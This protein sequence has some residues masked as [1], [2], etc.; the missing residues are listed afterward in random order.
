MAWGEC[1][2]A[3]YGDEEVLVHTEKRPLSQVAQRHTIIN[4]GV[5]SRQW[6]R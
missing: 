4:S 2:Q 3:Q 6:E 1:A 5:L